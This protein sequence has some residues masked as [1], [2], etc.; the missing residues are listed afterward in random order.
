MRDSAK[1]VGDEIEGLT[2]LFRKRS[3]ENVRWERNCPVGC[4]CSKG[5]KLGKSGGNKVGKEAVG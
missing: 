2:C 3:S 5:K 1:M 4:C